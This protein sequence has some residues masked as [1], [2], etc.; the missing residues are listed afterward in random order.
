MSKA[1]PASL[2]LRGDGTTAPRPP[3]VTGQQWVA[4][5]TPIAPVIPNPGEDQGG[6][7]TPAPT[8]PMVTDRTGL[9]V[10]ARRPAPSRVPP[11][12]G[13]LPIRTGRR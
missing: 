13:S 9:G 3:Q 10:V 5:G 12:R 7:G 4:S 6:P 8:L 1:N 2:P 11:L